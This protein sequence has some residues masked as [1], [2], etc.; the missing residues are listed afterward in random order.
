MNFLQNTYHGLLLNNRIY[1][2]DDLSNYCTHHIQA[3]DVPEWEINIY[4]FILDWLD[5]KDYI[6]QRSSGTT[7]VS[8]E[9]HLSKKSMIMSAQNTCDFFDIQFGNTPSVFR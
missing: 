5:D 3:G 1:P 9:L 4:K 8:K 2:I 7:G 6:I